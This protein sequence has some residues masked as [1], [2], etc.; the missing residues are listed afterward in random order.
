MFLNIFVFIPCNLFLYIAMLVLCTYFCSAFLRFFLF[1]YY[2]EIFCSAGFL[3]VTVFAIL[4]S[5]FSY[6]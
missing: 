6:W 5:T 2:N 4:I 3:E 1:N